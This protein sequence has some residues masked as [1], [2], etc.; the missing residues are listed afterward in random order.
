M[1]AEYLKFFLNDVKKSDR[2]KECFSSVNFLKTS[3]IPAVAGPIRTIKSNVNAIMPTRLA[4][5]LRSFVDIHIKAKRSGEKKSVKSILSP[6][7]S[8][9]FLPRSSKN[10]FEPVFLVPSFA[11]PTPAFS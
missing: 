9:N 2:I 6:M 1:I 7:I 8:Q 11:I 5:V 3:V 10:S 4:V